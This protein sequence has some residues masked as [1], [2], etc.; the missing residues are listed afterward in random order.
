MKVTEKQRNAITMSLGDVS[1]KDAMAIATKTGTGQSKVYRMLK[2][3]RTADAEVDETDDVVIAL[4]ELAVSRQPQ[5]SVK[6]SKALKFM[7]QLSAA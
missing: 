2:L 4:L 6:R 1:V 5:K 3:L 7:K